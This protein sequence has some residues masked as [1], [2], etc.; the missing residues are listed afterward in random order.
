MVPAF[1]KSGV[2]GIALL[3]TNAEKLADTERT[4]HATDPAI[5]TLTCALDISDAR[6]VENA[7]AAIKDK[8]GHSDIL[9]HAAGAASGDGPK[10]H[11]T[12]PEKWWHNFEVNGKGTYLLIRAFLRQ[13][14]TPDTP[15][16]IVNVSSWQPFFVAPQMSGY[17]ISKFILDNLSTYVAAEYPNVVATSLFPGLVP[18]DMLREPFGT[19]FE[20]T[21]AELVGSTAVWLCHEKAKFL[22]GRWISTNWDMEDLVSRKEEIIKGDLLK[23]TL[24]GSFGADI[25][26]RL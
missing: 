26:A 13:L 7:F 16:A 23:L 2:K 11:E 3:A 10:L 9:A 15:A 6:S 14:P 17:F 1:V 22:S 20:H 4:V 18:T 19:L 5:E 24:K 21:S 12:D 25:V 8:F